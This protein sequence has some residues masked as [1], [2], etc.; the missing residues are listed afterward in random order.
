VGGDVPGTEITPYESA[1]ELAA[2][3]W[4]VFP[5]DHPDLPQCAGPK[6]DQHDPK[7]CE[8][9]GKCPAIKW[10]TG[11][12]TS[13]HNIH[14]WWSGNPRNVALHTGKSG[15]LVVDEDAPDEFAKYAA[16]HGVAIPATYTV[17]TAKGKHYYFQDTEAGALGN[18]E[19]AFRDYAINVRSGRGYVIAPGSKH[20]TGV[21][22][23]A[24]GVST[25]APLPNW[26]VE[27]IQS[28]KR[29]NGSDPQSPPEG[30]ELPKVIK[31]GHRDNV[32]YLY[33]CSMRS[34][35]YPFNTALILMKDAWNRCEQPPVAKTFYEWQTAVIKLQA[36]YGRYDGGRSEEYQR[37]KTEKSKGPRRLQVTQVTDIAM[38]A[39][40]WLWEDG[41]AYWLPMGALVGL[42]G[43]EGV[44]KSTWCAYLTAMITKGQ[45]P[46]DSEGRP[47]GVIICSTED[48][49]KATIKPRLAAAGAAMD[50]VYQ[51]KAIQ[52]D[53]LEDIVSLPDDLPGMEKII[54]EK[55]VALVILDPLL[56]MVDK[57]FNTH[58][59]AEVRRALEPVVRLA[60]DTG[61]SLIGLIHVNKT[62]EGDLMNR[63]M[64]SRAIGA[65]VRGM[66]F[67]ARYK[68]VEDM[69]EEGDDQVLAEVGPKRSRFIFGQI[70]NNLQATVMHSVEYHMEGK[71]VG[72][73]VD[74][75]R[76]IEGSY[77]KIDGQIEE[78]I[79][80]LV[81]EQ[82]KRT[83][84]KGTKQG[85]SMVWLVGHMVGR[86]EVP[87]DQVI[88]AGIDAGHSRTSIQAARRNLGDRIQVRNLPVVPRKTTWELVGKA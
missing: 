54:R 2:R 26:V 75:E 32:L 28:Q 83:K 71:V 4:H 48:D 19:G 12:S 68:P 67:C 47:R 31:D 27:A 41:N 63:I 42:G 85:G 44:G 3:G 17:T 39:T 8:K 72:Y 22:Y 86:G 15:L 34:K 30:F 76:D 87:S 1:L 9:R 77:L 13:P 37:D 14:H 59:D 61:A 7:I 79:E 25:V 45:L 80:D 66:L 64:A 50:K 58:V 5:A 88:N 18:R 40:R 10:D 78:N 35:D 46:G 69:A 55:D 16:N 33:A 81:L 62:T 43:R 56:T 6:S 36:A 11:A 57:K 51:V 38:K 53:G 82:E 21:V 73:D 52:A 29:A 60:H 20:A 23:T 65:V 24:N 74:A 70:K 49:W 84:S